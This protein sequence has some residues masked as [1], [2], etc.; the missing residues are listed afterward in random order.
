MRWSEIPRD[1]KAYMIYHTL[2]SPS[3][4]M[5]MQ[6]NSLI[7]SPPFAEETQKPAQ[8]NTLRWIELPH[9][10]LDEL[11]REVF[12]I[13]ASFKRSFTPVYRPE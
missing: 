5:R 6:E 3:L 2:I 7:H 12:A 4:R 1:A 11:F 8:I 9:K 10:L 13:K